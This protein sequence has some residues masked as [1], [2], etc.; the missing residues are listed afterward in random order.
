MKKEEFWVGR[1]YRGRCGVLA[2]R[3]LHMW[4]M[5]RLTLVA[6]VITL[7]FGDEKPFQDVDLCVCSQVLVIMG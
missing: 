7:T 4:K 5:A 3:S 1:L 2:T 6:M